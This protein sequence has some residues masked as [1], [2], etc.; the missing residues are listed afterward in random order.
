[1]WRSVRRWTL[2]TLG[3]LGVT[4][5]AVFGWFNGAPAVLWI[6]AAWALLLGGI[7]YALGLHNKAAR[8][9][10]PL[11]ERYGP[12]SRGRALHA[13]REVERLQQKIRVAM[14]LGWQHDV[15]VRLREHVHEESLDDAHASLNAF[16]EA[17]V[18]ILGAEHRDLASQFEVDAASLST[19]D[20]I[21]D[22]YEQRLNALRGLLVRSA[23]PILSS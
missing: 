2:A 8:W 21:A 16:T 4:A 18:E 3:A 20:E 14:Q 1:M 19:L 22:A 17:L 5:Q 23:S 6:V 7:A 12:V 13:E 10:R 15:G 9:A 11:W